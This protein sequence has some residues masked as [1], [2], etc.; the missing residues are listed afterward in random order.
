[1]VD[2][3]GRDGAGSGAGDDEEVSDG[4]MLVDI[5]GRRSAAARPGVR[6]GRASSR[7]A[8][9]RAWAVLGRV[10]D[11]G[12]PGCGWGGKPVARRRGCP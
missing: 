5:H 8:R 3:A 9:C 2:D 10:V 6:S 12:S 7:V 11:D 4:A 1:M